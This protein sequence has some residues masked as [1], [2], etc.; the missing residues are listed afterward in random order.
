M[1]IKKFPKRQG[2]HPDLYTASCQISGIFRR[3]QVS[4]GSR[5][6]DITIKI[7]AKRIDRILPVRNPLNLIKKQIGSFIIRQPFLHI[8]V[9]ILCIHSLK[10]HGFKIHLNHLLLPYPVFLQMPDHQLHQTGFP[11]AAN[12]GNH[13][14]QLR[15]LKSNQSFQI[16]ITFFQPCLLFKHSATSGFIVAQI[17]LFCKFLNIHDTN[18]VF[19]LFYIINIKNKH[20][21]Y[22]HSAKTLIKNPSPKEH[23]WPKKGAAGLPVHQKNN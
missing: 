4:I 22:W 20:C 1:K 16:K 7:H 2:Q 3:K 23:S 10:L 14:D 8:S 11:A 15:I 18:F 21:Q 17:L 9:N 6:I 19:S 12:P 5:H 13:F